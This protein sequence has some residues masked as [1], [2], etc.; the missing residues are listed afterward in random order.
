MSTPVP[1]ETPAVAAADKVVISRQVWDRFNDA[2]D[3]IGWSDPDETVA[4]AH[5]VHRG[6]QALRDLLRDASLPI[7]VPL[8]DD[9][10]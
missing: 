3:D 1:S 9:D 7:H 5:A 4:F 6:F 2:V 8:S 10:V